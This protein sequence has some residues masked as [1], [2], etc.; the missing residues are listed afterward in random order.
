VIPFLIL[1]IGV[2]SSFLMIHEWQ[3]VNKHC[4]DYPSRKSMQVGYRVAELLSE[5]GPASEFFIY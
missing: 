2:D 5:V 4:R 1:A 3:R